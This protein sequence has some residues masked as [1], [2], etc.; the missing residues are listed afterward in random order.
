MFEVYW[1]Y[2]Y[3]PSH[4]AHWALDQAFENIDDAL[5][6]AA[7][8]AREQETTHYVWHQPTESLVAVFNSDGKRLTFPIATAIAYTAL[9]KISERKGA[10]E[11]Q[12]WSSLR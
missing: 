8:K 9:A 11:Y 2:S 10:S 4:T 6:Y 5:A 1:K 3:W 12:R 7:E